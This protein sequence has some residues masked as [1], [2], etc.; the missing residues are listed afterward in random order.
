MSALQDHSPEAYDAARHLIERGVPVFLL[1]RADTFPHGGSGESGYHFPSRWQTAEP[2]LAVLNRWKPGMGLAAVMGHVVDALDRDPRNGGE[3]P[4]HLVPKSY[5]R[6][7]T[8]S[9]GTHDLIQTLGVSSMDGVMPGVDVKAGQAGSGHG[10]IFLAPTEKWSKSSETVECY[11][12]DQRPWLDEIGIFEDETGQ[13]L[14]GL[15]RSKREIGQ[16][17]DYTGPEYSDLEPEQQAQADQYVEATLFDWKARLAIAAEWP[18]GERDDSGNG[19]EALATKSAW[20]VAAMAAAPWIELV[21]PGQAYADL[22]PDAIAGDKK[23]QGKWY[24]GIV[25]KYIQKEGYP[26][27]PWV[28]T[29]FEA[30]PVLQQI[31]T[32][33]YSKMRGPEGLLA[34]V[35]GRVL[36]E[37]PPDVVLPPKVGDVA[38]LNVGIALVGPSGGGKTSTLSLSAKVLGF[39]GDIQQAIVKPLGSGEGLAEMFLTEEIEED[40]ETGKKR[41]TGS[42]ILKDDPRAIIRIDEVEQIA[43]Q[44]QG[45]SGSTLMS[46]V[47]Q[48]LTGDMLG[49]SNAQAGGRT[50]LVPEKSYRAVM[51]VGVQPERSDVLLDGAGVGT[52]QRFLWCQTTDPSIPEETPEWPGDLD[53]TLPE[54]PADGMV[55]YPDSVLDEIRAAQLAMARGKADGLAGHLNLTRLKVAFALAILHS[56]SEITDRWWALAGVLMDRSQETQADCYRVMSAKTAEQ[57]ERKAVVQKKAEVHAEQVVNGDT[58]EKAVGMIARKLAKT[59]GEWVSWR[60]A[61]VNS[62]YLKGL[63]TEDVI[64]GLSEVQGVE[65]ET[66]ESGGQ[67]TYR[68]RFVK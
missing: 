31:K 64:E 34:T 28:D 12:W 67:T 42:F 54:M 36:A 32:A 57:I 39:V 48:A 40:E 62:K 38:S 27:P 49:Q 35:L 8:P 37:V 33:A 51:M 20:S 41:R 43:A 24:E 58:L 11:S 68:L 59:S 22:L 53:W 26:Q 7:R 46:T 18:D 19:W 10:F 21:N 2:D 25:E 29:L 17:E 60:N 6:Q 16:V 9:G 3:L 4:D 63:N 52:P 45:R 5:G 13:A 23:C 44:G 55:V 14:A 1:R 47:R 56:E 66:G 15:I 65:I 30:T 50:R 61:K